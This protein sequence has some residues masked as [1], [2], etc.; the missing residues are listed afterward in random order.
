[1]IEAPVEMPLA[2]DLDGTLILTDMS[3][4]SAKRIFWRSPWMILGVLLDELAGRRAKWKQD[5]ARRLVFDPAELAYH[6][7]FLD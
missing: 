5:L 7:A 1:M 3:A 6:E 2:V 4:L